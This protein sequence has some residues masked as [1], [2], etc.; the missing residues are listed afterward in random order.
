VALTAAAAV[1]TILIFSL[2]LLTS[3]ISPPPRLIAV[4]YGAGALVCHQQTERS[5]SLTGTQMP[6]CARCTGLYLAG[7]LCAL[8]AWFGY[9]REPRR[10]R[11]LLAIAAAPMAL[12]VG[13]EWMGLA[14]GSNTLR[15]ASALPAGGV[16]GWVIVRLLR[17]ESE[18]MRYDPVV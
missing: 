1:W 18:R 6:V 4:V 11:T 10:A 13:L 5:F 17:S 16:A 8:A 2:P 12:S 14:A 3:G 9:P 7:T 15:A